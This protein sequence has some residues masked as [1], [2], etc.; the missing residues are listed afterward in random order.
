M[1]TKQELLAQ[2]DRAR[3]HHAAQRGAA[4]RGDAATWPLR[5]RDLAR[6]ADIYDRML[7]DERVRRHPLP[8][9]LA[10]QRRA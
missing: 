3:R 5:A 6:A 9:R 4:G 1:F 7:R 8:G 10:G 2:N